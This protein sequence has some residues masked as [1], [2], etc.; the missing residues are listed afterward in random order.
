MKDF[1][2][3]VRPESSRPADLEEEEEEEEM[4]G[5]LN[6]YVARKRKRQESSEREPDQAEGLNRPTTDGGSEMQA[7]LIPGSLEMG[8]SDQPGPE[9]VAL[10]EPGEV[11]PIPPALQVIHPPDW[12]ESQLDMPKL[13][14]IGCRRSLLPDR[15]L[16]NSYLPLRG[17][18][19]VME[20][21]IVPGPKYI[22][23]I[24][25]RW[26]P[27]NQGESTAGRLDDLYPRTQ[28]MLVVARAGGLGEE[29]SVVVPIGIIKED[30]Q[31]IIEDGMQV[32][33]WNYIQSTKLVK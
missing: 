27:Y 16:L 11:T 3:W 32:R 29:N 10:G 22:K 33:N 4:I 8:S 20:E 12:A 24:I 2:P 25:H 9:D 21:V 14:R 17:P 30:L 23:H 6:L 1:V 31:Q 5:L 7:I 13:A 15:I 28:R 19:F 18:A 26:K